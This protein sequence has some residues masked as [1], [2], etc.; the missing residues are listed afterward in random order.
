MM[1]SGVPVSLWR[2]DH[3]AIE[4]VGDVYI[5]WESLGYFDEAVL[6]CKKPKGWWLTNK[7]ILCEEC[8]PE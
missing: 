6:E 8:K 1:Q 2:C 4:G 7:I 5:G 3:C